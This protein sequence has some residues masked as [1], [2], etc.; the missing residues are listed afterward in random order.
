MTDARLGIIVGAI[1]SG[2]IAIPGIVN[3][4]GTFRNGRKID[5]VKENVDGNLAKVN[6]KLELLTEAYL[7]LTANSSYDKGVADQKAV[8]ESKT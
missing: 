2:I 5:S 7:K 8:T 3:S 4:I 6:E 1:I